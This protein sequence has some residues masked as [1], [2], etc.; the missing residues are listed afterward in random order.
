MYDVFTQRTM[1]AVQESC[2]KIP[3]VELRDLTVS[4]VGVALKNLNVQSL[5]TE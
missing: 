5:F 4:A 2:R 1:K 3:D